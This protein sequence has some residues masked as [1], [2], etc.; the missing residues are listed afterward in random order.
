M[1]FA[2]EKRGD[3]TRVE[4]CMGHG[5]DMAGTSRQVGGRERVTWDSSDPRQ[6]VK[7]TCATSA[8]NNDLG[9]VRILQGQSDLRSRGGDYRGHNA[10]ML[11]DISCSSFR[12]FPLNNY[13]L[14]EKIS[15]YTRSP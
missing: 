5:S 3:S 15:A 7:T 1:K 6:Y 2:A 12:T 11:V 8:G 14:S 13:A 4:E 10:R 9:R